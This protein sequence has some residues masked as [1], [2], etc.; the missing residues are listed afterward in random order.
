MIKF[1]VGDFRYLSI[2][3]FLQLTEK[4]SFLGWMG[5]VFFCWGGGGG[6]AQ[7]YQ[8]WGMELVTKEP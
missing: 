4:V 5:V 8:A 3:E 6:V 2:F 1:H 7:E